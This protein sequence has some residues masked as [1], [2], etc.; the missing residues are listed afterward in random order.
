M[1]EVKLLNLRKHLMHFLPSVV[2]TLIREIEKNTPVDCFNEI[3][4]SKLRSLCYEVYIW[5]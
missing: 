5:K 3:S 4:P 1:R 2:A